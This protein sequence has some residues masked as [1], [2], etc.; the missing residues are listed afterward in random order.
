MQIN[1][2]TRTMKN[3]GLTWLMKLLRS[4]HFN[5]GFVFC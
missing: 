5:Y 2:A 3:S 1:A 4:S